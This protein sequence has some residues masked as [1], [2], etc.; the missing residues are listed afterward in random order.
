MDH[1]LVQIDSLRGER[2]AVRV[3]RADQGR[4]AVPGPPAADELFPVRVLEKPRG[5]LTVPDKSVPAQPDPVLLPERGE[6]VERTE[7]E[8]AF[9]GLYRLRLGFVLERQNV[10]LPQDRGACGGFPVKV[11]GVDGGSDAESSAES[12]E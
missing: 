1:D 9:L 8:P 7:N 11:P 4:E 2:E 6:A 12:T 5:D 10:E 3:F